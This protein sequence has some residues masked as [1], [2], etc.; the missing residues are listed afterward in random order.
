MFLVFELLNSIP[1]VDMGQ[2]KQDKQ[3]NNQT[4]GL[5]RHNSQPQSQIKS[6]ISLFYFIKTNKKSYHG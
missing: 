3:S 6:L 5:R 2:C 1:I 4:G